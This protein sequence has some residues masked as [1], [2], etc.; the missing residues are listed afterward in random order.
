MLTS[1]RGFPLGE[2][3]RVGPCDETLYGELVHVPLIVRLPEGVGA[4]GRSPALVEPADLWAT[5]LQCAGVAD[6]PPSPTAGSLLGIIREEVAEL[7]DRLC[8]VGDDPDRAIRT[9]AWYLRTAAESELYA[10]PDDRWEV[11][12]VAVRC[13]EVVES[14]QGVLAHYEQKL[15]AGGAAAELPPL[16][17][18]LRNGLQ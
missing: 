10:K 17:E 15:H 8:I 1:P 11:N 13:H 2:H 4:A 14:L 12:N 6:L 3:R 7:R 18:V 16:D 5:L 9:P